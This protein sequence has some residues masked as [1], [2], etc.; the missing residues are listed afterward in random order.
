MYDFNDIDK[1]RDL[2]KNRPVT[3]EDGTKLFVRQKES[4][5]WGLWTI[6]PEKGK[7]PKMLDGQ[8]TTFN[9]AYKA[10][11]AWSNTK[12][13]K[14]PVEVDR[15]FGVKTKGDNSTPIIA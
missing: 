11:I 12:F 8:F 6:H 9:D 4:N 1:Q 5:P 14:K 10:I 7:A 13:N 3:L 2:A 15:G